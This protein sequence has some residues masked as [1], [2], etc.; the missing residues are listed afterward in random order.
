MNLEEVAL[1][2]ISRGSDAR[3]IS[4]QALAAS[5]AG[6][7]EDAKNLLNEAEEKLQAAHKLQTELLQKKLNTKDPLSILLIHGQD[8]LMT[9]MAEKNLIMEMIDLYKRLNKEEIDK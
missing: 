8:H 4:Y 2:I 1:Q 9:A 6:D 5:K 3:N 7:F